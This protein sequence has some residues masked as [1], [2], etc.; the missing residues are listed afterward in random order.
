LQHR[1]RRGAVSVRPGLT[2]RRDANDGVWYQHV[3]LFEP[4]SAETFDEDVVLRG[5]RC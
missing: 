2:E 1:A 4:A 5:E 3:E